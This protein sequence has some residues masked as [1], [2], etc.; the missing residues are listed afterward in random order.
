[1]AAETAASSTGGGSDGASSTRPTISVVMPMFD[2]AGH[3]D[4]V[5]PPLQRALAAGEIL[6]V[7]VV[8]DG[9]RDD[10]PA[11]CKAAGFT[12]LSSGGRKGPGEARNVGAKAAKG[13]LVLFVDSDVVI[14]EDVPRRV[15]E[16]F[17]AKP[18][19]VAVFGAYD[20]HPAAPGLVSRYRNLLHHFVHAS[21]P[22]EASTFWAGCGAVRRSAFAKVGGFDGSAYAEPSIED[23]ELGGRLRRGGGRILLDPSIQGTHLK[24]W[25]FWKMLETDVLRRALPWGRLLQQPGHAGDVLNVTT[26]ERLKALVAG[27]FFLA[28]IAGIFRPL[29]LAV[30]AALLLIA[31]LAS[32]RFY[33]LVLRAAGLPTAIAAVFLHQLYFVY[34][35]ATYV[36]CVVESKLRLH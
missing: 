27:A 29:A 13:E 7:I 28:L 11:R 14:H 6:E 36:W 34:G 19:V 30:A 5:L 20:E 25:T 21:H 8:D 22:G 35:A 32:R 26:A 3:L 23:I 2:A 12:L 16:S 18:D 4:R 31:I 33:A 17:G 1:M 24:R 15:A 9:S 10:G